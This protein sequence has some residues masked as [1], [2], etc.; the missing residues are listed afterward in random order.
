M[1][2]APQ[3]RSNTAGPAACAPLSFPFTTHRRAGGV[4]CSRWESQFPKQLLLSQ[5]EVDALYSGSQKVLNVPPGSALISFSE[6]A[7]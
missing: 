4:V 2:G 3:S 7:R 5:A 1:T 6:R